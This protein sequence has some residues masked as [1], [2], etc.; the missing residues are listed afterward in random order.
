MTVPEKRCTQIIGPTGVVDSVRVIA[1]L[2][3][4]GTIQFSH[5]TCERPG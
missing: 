2:V 1:R 5:G 4:D 3:D